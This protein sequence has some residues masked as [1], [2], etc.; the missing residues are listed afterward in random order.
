MNNQS[1]TIGTGSYIKFIL[2]SLHNFPRFLFARRESNVSIEK[3]VS[4][5]LSLTDRAL[6]FCV[7]SGLSFK[8]SYPSTEVWLV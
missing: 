5:T 6:F 1:S 4:I 8:E 2:K 3:R 7:A